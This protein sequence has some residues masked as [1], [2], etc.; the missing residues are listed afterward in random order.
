MDLSKESNKRVFF[1]K[2]SI[3]LPVYNEYGIKT[4]DVGSVDRFVHSNFYQTSKLIPYKLYKR[5]STII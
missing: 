3:L 4:N 2:N 5:I 1:N